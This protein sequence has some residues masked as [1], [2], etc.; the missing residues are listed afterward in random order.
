MHIYVGTFTDGFMGGAPSEGLYIFDFDGDALRAKPVGI[1]RDVFSP[2]YLALDAAGRRLYAAERQLDIDDRTTG[3]ISAWSIAADG[4]LA[5]L[6][7]IASG[8]ANCAHISVAPDG[9]SLAVANPLGPT[10]ALCRLGAD[11]RPDGPLRIARHEGR[12]ARPR[13]AEPWP[14]SAYFDR[15]GA[16]LLA[17]DLAL[18]RI[19]VYRTDARGMGLPPGPQPF[20]QVHSGAGARHMAWSRDGATAYVANE[21]DSTLSVFA[22]DGESGSLICKQTLLSVADE[23]QAEGN[24]PAEIMVSPDG[25]HLYVSNRGADCISVLAIDAVTGRLAH[26]S[27]AL[28]HG[29]VPRNICLS[30]DGRFAFVANQLSGQIGLYRVDGASGTL[31][32]AGVLC[33]VPNPS[34]IVLF[35][36]GFG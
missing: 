1:A 15:D 26:A 17:C 32:Y 20:A 21:L 4:G 28:V 14:H 7:K 34:C 33:E 8:G 16:R 24:Q 9:R 29:R 18:D 35:D 19:F 23:A 36:S 27:Q 22:Y 3:A 5:P 10:V 31:A 2:S 25:R 13:Q 12:G 6:W 30:P 11:G